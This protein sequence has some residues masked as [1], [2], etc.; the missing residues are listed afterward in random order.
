MTRR[1]LGDAEWAALKQRLQSTG[2]IWKQGQEERNRCFVEAVYYLL[3]TGLPWADL[4]V[5]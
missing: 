2:R 5:V 4:P 3:R 1:M